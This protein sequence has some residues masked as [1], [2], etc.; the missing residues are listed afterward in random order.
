MTSSKTPW[1]FLTVLAV[2]A[3]GG[4]ALAVTSVDR[5][6]QEAAQYD[7]PVGTEPIRGEMTGW[8]CAARPTVKP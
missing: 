6:Q 3:L 2:V 8:F 4:V 7:C 1:I 5:E